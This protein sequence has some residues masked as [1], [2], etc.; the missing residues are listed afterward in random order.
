MKEPSF[1]IGI[2]EEYLLVDRETRELA[3]DVPPDLVEECGKRVKEGQVTP[4]FLQ[5]QIEVGTRV[6]ATVKE[7]GEELAYLRRLVAEVAEEYGFAPIAVSTHPFADWEQQKHTDKERYNVLARDMQAVARRLLIC[8][9]HTHVGID[10]DELRIDL[11]G[12]VSYFLPHLLALS[13]SSPFWRGERTGLMSYRLSVFDELPRTGL[14]EAFDSYSE[15]QRHLGIMTSA[16]LIEDASK[17][18]WDVRPSVRFPTLEMRIPDVCPRIEDGVCI[19]AL[20]LCLLRMLYRLKR[21]NQRWRRYSAMLVRENRW[22]AQRYGVTEG[23]V[24]FGKGEIVDYKGLLEEIL[25]LIH[26]DA[27]ALDCVA[28]VEH[29]RT[30]LTRGT[31]A[32]RQI[33]VYDKAVAEGAERQEALKSVVDLLIDES[34]AGIA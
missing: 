34:M 32:H 8:G 3:T 6:C 27:L 2:E 29:A 30:I 28:E 26:V 15:Y 31:S 13:T 33:E 18:W 16:G 1:T 12:Q 10:D 14:P 9:M 7:A 25:Q 19:A 17:I 22:R 4:E 23:L 5:S 20:Y 21:E 11:M 24:D